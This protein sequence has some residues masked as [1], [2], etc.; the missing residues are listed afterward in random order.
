MISSMN[1][2]QRNNLKAMLPKAQGIAQKF[3]INLDS[4]ANEINKL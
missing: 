3:G 1:P 4:V 2:A